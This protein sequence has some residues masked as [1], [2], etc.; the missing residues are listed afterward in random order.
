MFGGCPVVNN[1]GKIINVEIGAYEFVA[2][3]FEEIQTRIIRAFRRNNL[4]LT[5]KKDEDL[6]DG[7]KNN[8]AEFLLDS[9]VPIFLLGS[10][11][12]QSYI[13]KLIRYQF[14]LG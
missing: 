8:I 11:P 2:E 5:G 14:T 4:K 10:Y 7:I 13:S 6:D 1:T 9:D 12:L 3:F